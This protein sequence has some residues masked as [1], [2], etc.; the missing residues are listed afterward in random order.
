MKR[1]LL[2]LSIGSLI[3]GNCFAG[4][5]MIELRTCY[6]GVVTTTYQMMNGDHKPCQRTKTIRWQGQANID[7]MTNCVSKSGNPPYIKVKSVSMDRGF[8][9]SFPNRLNTCYTRYCPTLIFEPVYTH[10]YHR[11]GTVACGYICDRAP[12]VFMEPPYVAGE[13]PI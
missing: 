5:G 6:P 11:H 4:Y 9:A 2:A 13:S 12:V 7:D 1:F 10:Y 3:S 8:R